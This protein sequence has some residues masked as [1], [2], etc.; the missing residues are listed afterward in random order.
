MRLRRR[1]R[2]RCRAPMP[3]DN[4]R[5]SFRVSVAPCQ[6]FSRPII[7]QSSV[8]KAAP[9]ISR[10]QATFAATLGAVG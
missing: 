1:W 4:R 3:N 5:G 8:Q 2:W 10:V 7:R 9:V 6:F